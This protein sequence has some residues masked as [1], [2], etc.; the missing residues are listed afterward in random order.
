MNDILRQTIYRMA[1]EARE[2]EAQSR[3]ASELEF[4]ETFFA[5]DWGKY[6]RPALMLKE[7]VLLSVGINPAH[8]C[9]RFD[10]IDKYE[11]NTTGKAAAQIAE[12]LM[13]K[14]E[15][16]ENLDVEG[17]EI[18]VAVLGNNIQEHRIKVDDFVRFASNNGWEL[19]TQLLAQKSV[20][21][22]ATKKTDKTDELPLPGKLPVV[23][24]GA[25]AVKAAWQIE[26]E[27]NSLAT[28]KQVIKRLQEWA[29]SGKESDCLLRSQ[30]GNAVEWWAKGVPKAYD[31]DACRTTLKR[32]N[33]SRKSGQ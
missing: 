12:M 19:P 7:I 31:L 18:G 1:H 9:A 21:C 16:V 15:L 20:G 29:D 11:S 8:R 6:K 3:V 32:W 13:R 33:E 26:Q 17:G 30:K 25:L 24:C 5:V 22:E 2:K 27:T 23:A 28:A 10:W 4:D 14:K